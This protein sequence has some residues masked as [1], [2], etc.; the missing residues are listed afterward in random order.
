[1]R[2]LIS[3]VNNNHMDKYLKEILAFVYYGSTVNNQPKKFETSIS[4]LFLNQFSATLHQ[5]ACF[6][7]LQ[8]FRHTMNLVSLSLTL[9]SLSL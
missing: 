4:F 2:S 7:K 1:M 5:D 6:L 9:S 8:S 3:V